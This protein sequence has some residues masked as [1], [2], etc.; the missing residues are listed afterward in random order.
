MWAGLWES[1][2]ATQWYDAYVPIVA[3]YVQ[4]VCQSLSGRATA[5]LAQEARHLADHLG[6]SPAGMRTLGW[7]MEQVDAHTAELHALP[8]P[9]SDID[10]R[11]ARLT[12]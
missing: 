10:E 7:Q 2:Q 4:I 1:P 6:L 11:R 12:S 5:G 8:A 3:T 9:T